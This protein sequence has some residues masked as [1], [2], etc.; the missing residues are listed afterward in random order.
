MR[1]SVLV[2]AALMALATAVQA[3]VA[4]P[5][6]NP[7]APVNPYGFEQ[8]VGTNPAVL[9]FGGPSRVSV[10]MLD[11]DVKNVT[12][13]QAGPS[14]YSGTGY[15]VQALYVGDTFAAVAEVASIQLDAANSANGHVKADATAVGLAGHIQETVGVGVLHRNVKLDDTNPAGPSTDTV[16]ENTAGANVVFGE[17]FFIGVAAGQQTVERETTGFNGSVDRN[18]LRYGVAYNDRTDQSGVHVEVYQQK[19]DKATST[20]LGIG[21]SETTGYTAEVIFSNVLLS[22]ESASN[23]EYDVAGTKTDTNTTTAYSLGWTP[24]EQ[25]AVVYTVGKKE[26]R[27]NVNDGSDVEF[28][29]LG[30]AWQF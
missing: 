10:S 17:E 28:T 1:I 4:S 18:V 16:T 8:S 13:D 27:D 14:V 20:T 19:A 2:C 7:T 23:D 25:L 3:Q 9:P 11:A 30:V 24:G 29:R 12:A 15:P 5:R 22:Y 26:Q 21:K 6:Y